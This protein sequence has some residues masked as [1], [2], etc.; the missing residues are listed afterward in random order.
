[1]LKKARVLLLTTAFAPL[2]GGSEIAI[3]EIAKRIQEVHFDILT[4]RYFRNSPLVEHRQ[5]VSIYRI[6]LG[7]RA[8]KYLFPIVGFCVGIGLHWMRHYKIF[9]SYQASYGGVVGGLL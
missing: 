1:M 2:I 4:P 7:V 6:G 3:E 8:D 5:N 9:H